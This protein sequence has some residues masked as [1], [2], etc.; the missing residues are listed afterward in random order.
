MF[1]YCDNNLMFFLNQLKLVAT[2]LQPDEQLDDE[3]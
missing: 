1:I 2:D 3:Q